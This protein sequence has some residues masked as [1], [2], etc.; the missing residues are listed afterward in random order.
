VDLDNQAAAAAYERPLV[1]VRP[2]GHSAWRGSE[3]PADAQRI[4]DVV[5]GA[6]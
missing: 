4:I 3:Q 1:L 6:A 5:R 2:D